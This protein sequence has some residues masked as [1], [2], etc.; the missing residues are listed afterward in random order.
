MKNE[1]PTYPK[2]PARFEM[3]GGA[4]RIKTQPRLTVEGRGA[5]GVWDE[6]TRT[7]T[8][9]TS[10]TPAQQWRT[11]YHELAHVAFSDAG[12]DEMCTE[13]MVEALC[14]AVSTARMRERFG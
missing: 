14:D 1:T 12:V 8:V 5:W 13:P 7:I 3:P 2:L 4:V 10:A 9:D 11:L 6:N